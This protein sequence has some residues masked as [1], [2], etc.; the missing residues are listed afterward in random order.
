MV[1]DKLRCQLRQFDAAWKIGLIIFAIVLF[2]GIVS[3]VTTTLDVDQDPV[4]RKKLI[5][6]LQSITTYYRL[7]EQDANPTVALQH[8]G[9]A[10]GLKEAALSIASVDQIYK[11]T[12]VNMADLSLLIDQQFQQIQ[13]KLRMGT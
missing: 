4:I 13:A 11:T 10:K 6:F 1:F 7:S 2:L 8:I 3:R 5:Q 9:M 12:N